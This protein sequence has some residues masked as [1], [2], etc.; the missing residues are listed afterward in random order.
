MRTG[1]KT[2]PNAPF[3]VRDIH[4]AE[5]IYRIA[6]RPHPFSQLSQWREYF[7]LRNE[8]LEEMRR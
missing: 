1:V 8:Q 6:K 3:D 5:L 7:R 2:K 4:V